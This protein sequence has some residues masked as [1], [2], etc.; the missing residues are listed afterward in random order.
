MYNQYLDPKEGLFWEA[1][2]IAGRADT[3]ATAEEMA[4]DTVKNMIPLA[5]Q[6]ANRKSGCTITNAY[7]AL[8]LT[9]RFADALTHYPDAVSALDSL[10]STL[11]HQVTGEAIKAAR[12]STKTPEFGSD[13]WKAEVQ[14]VFSAERAAR[15]PSHTYF[16]RNPLTKLVK[17]GKS[18]D[19]RGRIKALQTAAGTSLEVIAVIEADVEA[20]LHNRFSGLR[21]H[22][23]WFKDKDGEI[24]KYAVEHGVAL[25][26]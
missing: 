17:I 23:E 20:T 13:E 6:I 25:T 10:C 1:A 14:K 24:H 7:E 2:L 5:L 8:A 11:L 15:R 26:L 21:V 19:V 22:G 4:M 18:R 9:K 16:V 12:E 3:A